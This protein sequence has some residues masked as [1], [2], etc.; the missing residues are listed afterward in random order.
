[1]RDMERVVKV[2]LKRRKKVFEWEYVKRL[3]RRVAQDL[4]ALFRITK[5]RMGDVVLD[6]RSLHL[7]TRAHESVDD[8]GGRGAVHA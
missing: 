1:M 7:R 8:A 2:S 4:H 3:A 5:A 6:V